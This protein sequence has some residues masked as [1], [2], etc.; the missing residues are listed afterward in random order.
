MSGAQVNLVRGT[1][2]SKADSSFGF[3]PRDPGAAMNDVA[4]QPRRRDTLI[5]ISSRLPI[6]A[7]FG[8][9]LVARRARPC[10]TQRG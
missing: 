5:R 1:V 10:S 7:L 2:Q 6:P 8:L 9:R 3:C 4:R